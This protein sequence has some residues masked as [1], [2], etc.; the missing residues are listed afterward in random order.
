M[1]EK[2]TEE[3]EFIY[4]SYCGIYCGSCFVMLAYTQNRDGTIPPQ[5]NIRDAELKCHG[6][7]SD[8]LFENCKGFF[9]LRYKNIFQFTYSILLYSYCF[10]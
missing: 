8:I 3:S 10:Y 6:C 2:N 5:W 7:K 9:Y 1:K 4:D